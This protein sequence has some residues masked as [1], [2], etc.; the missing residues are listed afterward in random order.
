LIVPGTTRDNLAVAGSAERQVPN[1]TEAVLGRTALRDE[2]EVRDRG[3]D[4]Q[5]LRDGDDAGHPQTVPSPLERAFDQGGDVVAQQNPG[6]VGCED[7]SAV[8]PGTAVV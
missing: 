8:P 6:F 2:H 1:L 7:Q 5:R 3:A 4:R